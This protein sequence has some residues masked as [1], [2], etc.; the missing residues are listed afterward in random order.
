MP[1]HPTFYVRRSV[2]GKH[3]GFD[4]QYRLQADFELTMR[5]L[6]VHRIKSVYIPHVLVK[7]RLGGATNNSL[8]NIL[9]GNFEAYRACQKHGLAVTPFFMLRKVF[10]RLPQFFSKPPLRP[11]KI[12]N[13]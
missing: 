12:G 7:M 2:F 8:A 4:L 3:G 9:Q 11:N 6:E 10:S 1:A 5:L 13:N